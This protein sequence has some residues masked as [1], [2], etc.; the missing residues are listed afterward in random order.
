MKL[1]GLIFKG[2]LFLLLALVLLGLLTLLA[3]WLNWPVFTGFFILAGLA[4]LVLLFWA[5][6][7]LWRARNKQFFVQQAISG[8]KNTEVATD[9]DISGI[10]GVWRS[11]L[12][13][14]RQKRVDQRE[15]LGRS[16]YLA[17]DATR[18]GATLSPVFDGKGAARKTQSASQTLARHD[19]AATTLLH[20]ASGSLE[21]ETGEELLTLLARDVPG[22]AISGILLVIS[23][24]DALAKDVTLLHEWGFQLRNALYTAMV[25]VNRNV[26]L[27]LLVQDLETLPGG[28][29]L[30]ARAKGN[31]TLPGCF[32]AL[33][34][35]AG[36]GPSWTEQGKVAAQAADVML[37]EALYDDLVQGAPAGADELRFLQEVGWLGRQLDALFAA[38]LQDVPR[39][40]PVRLSGVFF[41]PTEE[42]SAPAITNLTP[43]PTP[44]ISFPAA[45]EKTSF[46]TVPHGALAR[47]LSRLLP[48]H[49][50]AAYALRGRF[51][52]YSNAKIVVMG[53]W[54]MVLFC[55]CGL[56][57]AS[58]LYQ[59]RAITTLPPSAAQHLV[60]GRLDVL[61]GE[62]R[63]IMQLEA[64]RKSW[65][66][67]SLGLDMLARVERE[68]KN[69]FTQRLYSEILA[70]M[71]I[72]M[73][74][75]LNAPGGYTEVKH[76]S[77]NQ[78][79]WLGHAVSEQL[80]TGKITAP[81]IFFPLASE[82]SQS[83][84]NGELIKRGLEWTASPEQLTVLGQDVSSVLI[85]FLT[86][87]FDVFTDSIFSYYD[88]ANTDQQVCLS[89]YWPHL[90]GNDQD[91]SCIPASYTAAGY[92]LN[93]NFLQGFLTMPGSEPTQL[94]HKTER[95]FAAYY[96][97]YEEQW[98][99][100]TQRFC[101]VAKSLE[102][103][104]VYAP[105]ENIKNLT[106]TPH[107]R[108][109]SR[110]TAELAP[111][112][113]AAKPPAWLSRAHLFDVMSLVALE[114]HASPNPADWHTLLV[115]GINA[116]EVL[117]ELW[118]AP[119]TRGHV[120]EIYDGIM[121]MVRYLSAVR[122]IL[123]N[124]D[125]PAWSLATARTHFGVRNAEAL[126]ESLYAQGDDHRQNAREVFRNADFPQLRLFNNLLDFAGNGITVS[127]ALAL[128]YDWENKVLSSPI[129]LHRGND[130]ALM[131]GQEGVV[132]KFVAEEL[133]PFLHRQTD[134]IA[135]AVWD[136]RAFPFTMDFLY[137]LSSSE[138]FAMTA[139]TA[140]KNPGVLLRSLPT[141]LNVDAKARANSTT[142]TLQCQEKNWQ[143]I[144]RNYPH[145][146]RFTYDKNRC[147]A[148]ELS[149]A[150][151]NFEA[152]LVYPD[153]ASFV[154]DFQYGERGFVPADFPNAA[155]LLAAA[156][157]TNLKVRI[158]PD[159]V[160]LLL[161][162][163]NSNIPEAP[164]RITY[165]R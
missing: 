3:W 134:G 6:R 67:P 39:Q 48:A 42:I 23:A 115:A 71:L 162:E 105:F 14:D 81:T 99:S 133:S 86:R 148:T 150:F 124:I 61:H 161:R 113:D 100:F 24:R 53:A 157:V 1:L 116:P 118:T 65:L 59:N 60:S 62:M 49:G 138:E 160:A 87:N 58:V 163:K 46:K 97:R 149:I 19:F 37:R 28:E 12:L 146:E 145:N 78:L 112:K 70:P 20:V 54:C 4:G 52:A 106:E 74:A 117:R 142:L 129:R 8:L 127:A 101:E 135:A 10:T 45:I 151:P 11:L 104:N 72:H 47:F 56:M 119:D 126:K 91:D 69:R 22:R 57:A 128:Q 75:T 83:T 36:G 50:A 102:G 63:Y 43:V 156:G 25:A 165:V 68:E 122:G 137:F 31:E 123:D 155:D 76:A 29:V 73:R 121:A 27:Y 144:N 109:V 44:I 114:G 92:A 7:F 66:L 158:S 141:L 34:A 16:W 55:V 9:A 41:C 147:G 32:F 107:L 153:F 2:L 93:R 88:G 120:R 111:L 77:V 103:S 96:L 64:A 94:R 131:F 139:A 125:N 82:A 140:D 40:D 108:L 80:A 136:K 26:P 13:L 85:P 159:N 84:V 130:A 33:N 35:Q 38:L 15:F 21:G 90:F 164:D 5:G 89:H 17:L 98:Q 154:E 51:S 110:L 152:K 95:M 79:A 132:T 143:L 30:L 18:D